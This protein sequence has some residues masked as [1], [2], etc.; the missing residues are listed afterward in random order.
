[1]TTS[2]PDVAHLIG[3]VV[4]AIAACVLAAIHT[5]VPAFV[6]FAALTLIGIGG[7]LSVAPALTHALPVAQ[8]GETAP[9]NPQVAIPAPTP[10]PAVPVAPGPA[11]PPA[12][13]A[14]AAP[15]V[16]AVTS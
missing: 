7:G 8:L 6:P 5:A 12:P 13:A 14:P 4:L 15:T 2:R 9:A 16:P 10:T 11:E 1:M 3:G